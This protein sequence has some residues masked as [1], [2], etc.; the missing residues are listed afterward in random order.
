MTIREG[1]IQK[2]MALLTAGSPPAGVERSRSEDLATADLPFINLFP[3]V[4]KVN[5]LHGKGEG[6]PSNQSPAFPVEHALDMVLE[7]TAKASTGVTA[8]QACDAMESWVIQKLCGGDW[9]GSEAIGATWILTTWKPGLVK[10]VAVFT[11]EVTVR[12]FFT[13]RAGD[14][15]LAV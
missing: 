10:D 12:V 8:D 13:T 3:D 6:A 1:V 4:D 9:T 7:C 14:P 11:A 2:A 5:P 15:T